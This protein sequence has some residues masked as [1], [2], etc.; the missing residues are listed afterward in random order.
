M[1]K[2]LMKNELGIASM[3]IL[4]LISPATGDEN[5]SDFQGCVRFHA[6]YYGSY[7]F[8]I[9]EIKDAAV[10]HCRG[11]PIPSLDNANL[12]DGDKAELM[13][14]FAQ[15]QKEAVSAVVMDWRLTNRI[16]CGQYN[17]T[18]G[19]GGAVSRP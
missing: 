12:P 5:Y 15:I 17:E 10:A 8:P 1:I 14:S 13:R 2:M 11:Q 7:C 16:D 4:S 19:P 18:V 3:L 6:Q 9:D